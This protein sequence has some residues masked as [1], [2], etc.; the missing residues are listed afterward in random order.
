[1]ARNTS[2]E[3]S[4]IAALKYGNAEALKAT[5]REA[6]RDSVRKHRPLDGVAAVPSGGRDR[7]GRTYNYDEG[8]N[9]MVEAG[10]RRWPGVEYKDDDIKGKG[11]PSYSIDKALQEHKMKAND[12]DML[13][14]E[15]TSRPRRHKSVNYA[16][17]NETQPDVHRSNSTSKNFGSGLRKRFGSLRR[18]KEVPS[19][20]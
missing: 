13:G 2:W 19:K 3:S 10:Y 16:S 8:T 5:P 12:N 6:I 11:E 17:T 18:R 9:L 20:D 1:M 14:M 15:L 4:P 7:F